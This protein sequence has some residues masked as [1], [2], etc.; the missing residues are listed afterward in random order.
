MVLLRFQV[1]WDVMLCCSASGF[2]YFQGSLRT[3][4]PTTQYHIPEAM[5]PPSIVVV[6][7]LTP[8]KKT[9]VCNLV[10]KISFRILSLLVSCGC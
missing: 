4:Q 8:L 10:L 3:A 7:C 6:S 2:S 9:L 1:L 5:D